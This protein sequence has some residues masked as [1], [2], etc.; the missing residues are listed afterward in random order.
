MPNF[1]KGHLQSSFDKL[2]SRKIR[3]DQL[4]YMLCS[5]DINHHDIRILE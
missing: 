5:I 3:E 1:F 2:P 4:L